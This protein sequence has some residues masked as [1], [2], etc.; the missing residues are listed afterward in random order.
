MKETDACLIE[1]WHK[2][3]AH[4]FT[5]FNFSYLRQRMYDEEPQWDY[6]TIARRLL[7]QARNALDLGTGGG[8]QLEQLV[9][10]LATTGAPAPQQANIVATEGY[11]PNLEIARTT[12]EPL[13]VRV[14][15]AQDS[16]TV[17][18]PFDAA[19]FDLIMNRHSAFNAQEIA[20]VLQPGGTFITQ[21]VDG[22]NLDDLAA[23]FDSSNPW[24]YYS[25]DYAVA[26]VE[27]AGLQIEH[28]QSW[29]GNTRFQDVGAIVYYLK[30]I[31][32]IVNG[33]S[34]NKHLP[35]LRAL[36]QKFEQ[37]CELRFTRRLFW[38]QARK[39]A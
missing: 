37:T 30:A 3:E 1:S 24:L 5:G 18:L 10:R 39:P 17:A 20:R 22:R 6:A 11:P 33:F 8:E 7:E 15:H 29:S 32:W 2:E 34:V 4:P 13:G 28:A 25:L 14:V 35:N 9:Q 27:A 21:Q 36:Q 12:L 23:A 16:A 26:R 31:P 38:I 19:H